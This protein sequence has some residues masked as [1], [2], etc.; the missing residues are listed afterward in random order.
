[1]GTYHDDDLSPRPSRV[2]N[3]FDNL[4]TTIFN[5]HSHPNINFNESDWGDGARIFNGIVI[6]GTAGDYVNL[7]NN[8]YG[9]GNFYIYY[10][11]WNGLYQYTKEQARIKVSSRQ[12]Q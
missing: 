3:G 2:F 12:I 1:M 9:G 6:P 11:N 4:T 10:P 5:V 7:R 8:M